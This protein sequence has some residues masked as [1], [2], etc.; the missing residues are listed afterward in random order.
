MK[1]LA[2]FL[3]DYEQREY[4]KLIQVVAPVLADFYIQLV[5]IGENFQGI[6][7]EFF[8]LIWE[9][10]W[11]NRSFNTPKR[12][13][14]AFIKRI[15][16]HQKT[17]SGAFKPIIK[18]L[19]TQSDL[20][21][22]IVSSTERLLS[23]VKAKPES[24]PIL[25]IWAEE[26]P[27]LRKKMIAYA[28]RH[29]TM[30]EN[31]P[32]LTQWLEQ[33]IQQ[34]PWWKEKSR[35]NKEQEKLPVIKSQKSPSLDD[36]IYISNAG[37][38]LVHPFLRR[39][40]TILGFTEKNQFINT[41]VQYRAVHVL[42]YLVNKQLESDEP[43]L[44][45]NKIMCGLD[46]EDP[47]PTDIVLSEEEKDICDKMLLGLIRQWA[48]LK[49]VTPD[50][51]RAAFFIRN[52]RLRYEFEHWELIVEKKGIDVLLDHLPWSISAI[53]LHWMKDVIH[54]IWG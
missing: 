38:I 21:K 36:I 11:E 17:I 29:S 19:L 6:S 15:L 43:S 51:L 53:Q 20:R 28:E 50:S 47:V 49:G 1:N 22:T 41:E 45:L 31:N 8:D 32:L 42:Q 40:F 14:E 10:I 23:W 13:L 16:L 7:K 35:L 39:L 48:I 27:E 30:I 44:V 25:I 33:K 9:N 34:D 12:H 3:E 5:L 4:S 52:G 2:I 37:L 54:I 18:Q 26:I 24:T 46:L